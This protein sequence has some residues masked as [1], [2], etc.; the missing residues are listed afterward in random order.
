MKNSPNNADIKKA[1]DEA[2]KRVKD[3]EGQFQSNT[4]Q[5]VAKRQ[6]VSNHKTKK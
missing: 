1:L 2:M 4:A 6:L 5:A 3:K